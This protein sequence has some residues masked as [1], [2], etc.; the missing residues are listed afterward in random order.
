MV[1]KVYVAGLTT[2]QTEQKLREILKQYVKDPQ[3]SVSI[4]EF[5]S[6]PI[7]VVGSFSEAGVQMLQGRKTLLEV[8]SGAKGSART[9]ARL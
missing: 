7:S 3:V 9:P 8:V 5:R 4:Q 2:V 6:Q 1:G